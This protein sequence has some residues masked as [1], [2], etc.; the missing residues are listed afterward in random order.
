MY[1]IRSYYGR[2]TFVFDEPVFVPR[3]YLNN[4]GVW[5]P[6]NSKDIA[7]F[8][9]EGTGEDYSFLTEYWGDRSCYDGECF[10]NYKKA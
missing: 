2:K 9:I 10:F 4:I 5:A 7:P 1:A 3:N 8:E 6:G